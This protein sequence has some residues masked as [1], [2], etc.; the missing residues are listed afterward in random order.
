M[1]NRKR[2]IAILGSTGSI[3]RQAVDVVIRYPELFEVELLAANSNFRLLAEQASLTDANNAVICKEELYDEAQPLFS[4]G[5]TKLFSGME[6]VCHLL[7]DSDIDIV[8]ASM[9]GFSGLKP[10]VS[11]LKSGKTVAIANKEILVSAGET[12]MRLSRKHSAALIPVDSE[13]SAIFQ[14]LQG[15]FGSRADELIITA[16][17]GPFRKSTLEEMRSVTPEQALKH[18]RW[19]MGEKVTIDSA[20]LMNKGFEVIEARWLFGVPQEKIKVVVHP[21][22]IIHSMVRFEDGAV[23]AQMGAQDMRIPI[24][25]ALTYPLRRP[26]PCERLDFSSIGRLTFEEPD[27]E[28]F[29]ALDTAY[30]ALARG[31]NACCI[32]SSADEQAV[33]AFIEGK[34]P[35]TA[36]HEVIEEALETVPFIHEPDLDAIYETDRLAKTKA[37]EIIDKIK[38]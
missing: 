6:S 5:N 36:I 34:I 13:H 24:Q 1:E 9:V 14:C 27:T 15:A 17:G 18:P 30:R 31:G 28:R 25:Y 12:V 23:L 29:P 7:E 22:S 2:K 38:K 37:L 20:T 10:A 8:L 32:M 35:F 16:S 11:A 3:G 33:K 19:K 4:A 21:E 26:S